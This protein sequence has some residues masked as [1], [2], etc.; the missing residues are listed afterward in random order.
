MSKVGFD[1]SLVFQLTGSEW[2]GFVRTD[3]DYFQECY[4][5]ELALCE[6]G[7]YLSLVFSAMLSK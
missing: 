7:F 1:L 5:S 3:F 6:L 4:V 2:T